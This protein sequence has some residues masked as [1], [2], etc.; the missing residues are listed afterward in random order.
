[1]N[2]FILMSEV[3]QKEITYL[4]PPY[5]PLGEITVIDGDPGTNKSS[6]TLDLAARVSTGQ[7]MPDG[8]SHKAGGV[9]F[10]AAEDSI[11]KTMPLRLQAAGA[12]LARIAA[13][14]GGVTIPADLGLIEQQV[15]KLKAKLVVIDPLMAF[16]QPDATG[17]QRVRQAL[18]PLKAFAE[19]LNL[20]VI[21]IR[22]MNKSGGQFSLYRGSGSIGIIG[23]T[24]SAL[25]VA[26]DPEDPNMRVLCHTKC[27]LAPR[28]PSLLFEPV[29]HENGSVRIE[30]QGEC[31]YTADD[32]LKR[33]NGRASKQDQAQ[34]F[35]LE[36]LSAGPIEQ[37]VIQKDAAGLG[38]AYR[39]VERAKQ[40][41]EIKSR[42]QGFGPGSVILWEMPPSPEEGSD[43]FVPA[44][45]AIDRQ[46]VLAVY[47][48]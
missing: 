48:D 44:A 27:N 38:I 22:H 36:A 14:D 10:L 34:S 19:R 39:T 9:V 2:S 1:M 30:W 42:R 24:R 5:V 17:D 21:L 13:I 12:D 33:A 20:S 37:T 23:A 47:E 43:E 3:Q 40:L 16:L 15:C 8:T 18:T 28:G 46:V 6:I 35:L 25:L 11:S 41:L 31:E 32:L 45:S 4:W 29:S 7:S 26:N